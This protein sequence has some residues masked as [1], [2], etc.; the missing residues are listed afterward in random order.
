MRSSRLEPRPRIAIAM[1]GFLYLGWFGGIALQRWR[2]VSF[3]PTDAEV[4]RDQAAFSQ[5]PWR[6]SVQPRARAVQGIRRRAKK[7]LWRARRQERGA[8]FAILVS[9]YPPAGWDRHQSA[10]TQA[11]TRSEKMNPASAALAVVASAR[12]PA[13]YQSF[14]PCRRCPRSDSIVA[15]EDQRSAAVMILGG[16]GRYR[17]GV[18]D[19]LLAP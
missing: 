7:L 16:D 3:G 13:E 11:S 9:A 14:F 10:T 15:L 6:R 12:A 4:I 19:Q 2:C 5:G 1:R 8:G 18:I 17:R